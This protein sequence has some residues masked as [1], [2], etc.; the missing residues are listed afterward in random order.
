MVLL[1]S[2]LVAF[3]FVLTTKN[4]CRRP[5]PCKLSNLAKNVRTRVRP[6]LPLTCGCVTISIP[7]LIL[8]VVVIPLVKLLDMLALPAMRTPVLALC[9]SVVPTVRENGF[10][11]VT[12]R[13]F[14]K[15]SV[16]YP[17]SIEVAG[18]M[19]GNRC[20]RKLRTVAHVLS[21]PSFA[22][23]RIVFLRVP[24]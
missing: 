15:L 10:R 20:A 9:S 3:T 11:T 2:A 13:V 14:G 24:S 21:L 22:A 8:L 17:L 1:A 4:L 23:S 16:V 19:C 18:S 5:L 12:T 6:P 7:V